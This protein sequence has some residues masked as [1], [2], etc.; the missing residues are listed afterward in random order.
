MDLRS[1]TIDKLKSLTLSVAVMRASDFSSKYR[2]M[3]SFALPEIAAQC[4]TEKP[5]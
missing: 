2:V 3:E 4:N 5:F 1:A